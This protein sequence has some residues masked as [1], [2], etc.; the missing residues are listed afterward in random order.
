MEFWNESV[1]LMRA[2]LRKPSVCLLGGLV[3]IL[4]LIA[5]GPAQHVFDLAAIQNAVQR[6]WEISFGSSTGSDKP[7]FLPARLDAAADDFFT[8][9]LG[10]THGDSN[11]D[12][13]YR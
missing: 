3:V 6:D 1:N 4:I 2:L 13:V 10:H 8:R 7:A 11:R 5:F 12:I 9:I